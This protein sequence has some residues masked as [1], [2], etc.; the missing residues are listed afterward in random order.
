M[1]IQEYPKALYRAGWDDLDASVTVHSAQEEASAR[2]EGYRGLSEPVAAPGTD[3]DAPDA[4]K[5]RG[6]P[7]KA[8]SE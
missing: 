3:D 7:P 6:R 1:T 8:I 4:P 2:A 5:R